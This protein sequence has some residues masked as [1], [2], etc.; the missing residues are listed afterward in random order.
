MLGGFSYDPNQAN[1]LWGIAVVSQQQD[2]TLRKISLPDGV[3]AY[4][5]AKSN[6]ATGDREPVGVFDAIPFEQATRALGAIAE[7]IGGVVL[8]A[9]PTKASVE[10]GIEFMVEEGKLVSIIAKGGGAANLKLKL[11]WKSSEASSE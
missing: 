2:T 3:T 8:A 11:E 5:E 1:G 6:G 10:L 4:V 9:K 7:G